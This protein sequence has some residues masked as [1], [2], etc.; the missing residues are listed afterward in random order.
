MNLVFGSH[1]SCACKGKYPSQCLC[2][3]WAKTQD[4]SLR[5]QYELGIRWFDLRYS[6]D[7]IYTISHTFSSMYSVQFAFEE[8]I[9]CCT[10]TNEKIYI[11]LKRDSTSPSLPEFGEF[12]KSIT[13]KLLPLHYY[14]ESETNKYGQ[15][16]LYT[17]SNS[18]LEDNVPTIWLRSQLFDTIETWDCHSVEEASKRIHTKSF[19]ENGLPKAIFL[20]FSSNYPPEIAFELLWQKV[21]DNIIERI[22]KKQIQCLV[23]N[24]IS[25]DM[26]KELI[27]VI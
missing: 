18:T 14:I 19:L 17:D 24:H 4:I 8:L 6:F 10:E 23:M 16:I 9:S 22:K 3:C 25:Y 13:I 2:W 20:D 12:L 26:M 5:K 11:R 21:K 27:N 15:I 1:D 7:E